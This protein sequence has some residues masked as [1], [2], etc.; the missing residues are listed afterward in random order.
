MS[1]YITFFIIFIMIFVFGM[2]VLRVGLGSFS[3]I[4]LKATLS[5]MT[6]TTW[7]GMLAG[8]LLTCIMQSS[9]AVMVITV[10]LVS[11]G[12][13]SFKQ[14]IGVILGTN[15]GTTITAEIIT[16]DPSQFIL[17]L[18]V[19]GFILIQFSRQLYFCI[20]CVLF[21]L[22]CLFVAMNGFESL[23]IPLSKVAPIHTLLEN[24]NKNLLYGVGLGTVFTALIQSSSA[25][26]GIAMSFINQSLLSI[27]S[28]IA[29][30]FGANIGTCITA[31]IASIG[32]T[33]EAKLV[34]YA[35][36]WLNIFGVIFFFPLISTLGNI[37]S[38][39]TSLP[40]LQLAHVSVLFNVLS[41]LLVLP[42]AGLFAAFVLK[43]HGKSKP[44]G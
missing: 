6:N 38:L 26:T 41:S 2:T 42:F 28:A 20:G 27:D 40:D 16:L 13:L 10:G 8:A 37:S 12:I 7:K 14:S 29:I 32:T 30:L 31:F 24:S 34:A 43:L 36:I 25:T 11:V 3:P 33:K 21:G 9:S 5:K 4:R 18:L 23:A 1:E 22:G 19:A 17:P 15:I 39:V 35:H 44:T